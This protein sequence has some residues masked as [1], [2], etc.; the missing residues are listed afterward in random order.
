MKPHNMSLCTLV[1]RVNKMNN[2]LEKFPPR[3]NRTHQVKLAEDKLMDILE[4]A[5]PKFWQEEMQRQ[6]FNC[7][8]EGQD[9]FIRFCTCLE[10]LDP[11]KQKNIQYATSATGSNQQIPKKEKSQCTQ[12][13]R[14]SNP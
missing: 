7:A 10:S 3:D 2:L 8:A 4:N 1:V 13:D 12:L 14:E 6:R 9:K 5:V 11:P